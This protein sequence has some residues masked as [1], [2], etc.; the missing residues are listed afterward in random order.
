MR[1]ERLRVRVYADRAAM[2][3]AAGMAV[4]TALRERLACQQCVRM[5]FAAAPS[6]G[7]MLAALGAAPGIDW[8][9]VTAFHMDEYLDLASDAP[10]RFGH[11]LREHLFA[12][13]EPGAVHYLAA[14]PIAG[15]DDAAIATECARYTALLRVAPIDIVCLGIGENGHLAF[16]DPPVADFA[17][18]A[19]VK[20]V[21]LDDACRR[22]QVHDGCFAALHEVPTSAIT[23]TVPA[24]LQANSIYCIV[25]GKNKAVAVYQTL[26][27]EVDESYPS[28]SLKNHADAT[29]YIDN[30]SASKL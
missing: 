3:M 19:T 17:D 9:R 5:I 25:P 23:L 15:D 30:E 6:Q 4:A 27:S 10:Q 28:T 1:V 29:L 14:R 18:P 2:G 11:F 22:Q 26:R 8:T 24:L 12:R 20:P 16:N 13:V 21:E 7:E